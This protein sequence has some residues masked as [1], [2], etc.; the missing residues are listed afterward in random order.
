MRFYRV[1]HAKCDFEQSIERVPETFFDLSPYQ[2]RQTGADCA[3]IS[4]A[5]AEGKTYSVAAAAL[6]DA[7]QEDGGIRTIDFKSYLD[8]KGYAHTPHTKGVSLEE[9]WHSD[10]IAVGDAGVILAAGDAGVANHAVGF[11]EGKMYVADPILTSQL[12]A[13]APV[14]GVF[15]RKTT[16]TAAIARVIQS[17]TTQT[18]VSIHERIMTKPELEALQAVLCKKSCRR[19]QPLEC[20]PDPRGCLADEK[21]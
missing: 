10:F 4:V 2:A 13:S 17:Q 6:S 12:Y 8:G 19:S 11:R 16:E 1:P 18:P 7:S 21:A 9:L 14:M 3:V 20:G 5:I 15:F